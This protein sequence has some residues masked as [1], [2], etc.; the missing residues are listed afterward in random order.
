MWD[1]QHIT[2][3]TANSHCPTS[4]SHFI[5]DGVV[6]KKPSLPLMDKTTYSRFVTEIQ[7]PWIVAGYY[8]E[9]GEQIDEIH[10]VDLDA[11]SMTSLVQLYDELSRGLELP[12]YFGRNYNALAECIVDLDWLPPANGYLLRIHNPESLLKEEAN[13]SI[14]GFLEILNTASK[15]RAVPVNDGEEWDRPGK[16]FHTILVSD[17]CGILLLKLRS[18]GL[19]IPYL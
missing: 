4:R 15:E 9:Q 14:V 1:I 18:L 7:A 11:D 10:S 13:H 3:D 5:R 6:V 19:N 2:L 16:P 8:G 12:N 17:D